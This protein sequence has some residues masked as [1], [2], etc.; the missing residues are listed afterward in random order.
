MLSLLAPLSP[1]AG[2]GDGVRMR[3]ASL[4]QASL[5]KAPTK[6]SP[7]RST[8]QDSSPQATRDT[9]QLSNTPSDQPSVKES[10]QSGSISNDAQEQGQWR[11]ARSA[12][13]VML[14]SKYV[15]SSHGLVACRNLSVLAMGQ[16][17]SQFHNRLA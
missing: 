16:T 8:S 15:L 2:K 12:Q 10:L 1:Y 7:A 17:V 13:A 6:D 9:L 5:S 4:L 14:T 3:L 11:A